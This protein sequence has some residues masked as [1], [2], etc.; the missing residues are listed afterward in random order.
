MKEKQS[1]QGQLLKIALPVTL[2]SLLQSS[3]SIV[4]Q[5]M[6]GQLGSVSIAGIGM[7]SKFLSLYTVVISAVA[8][9][10]GIMIAQYIGNRNGKEVGRS[11]YTN[12][13]FAVCI[14]L[15]FTGICLI[16]PGHI[17]SLYS[18]DAETIAMAS[19]Y[20]RIFSLSCI[21]AALAALFSTCLRCMGYASVPL[22]TTI[23]AAVL[24]TAL[25]YVMIFGRFGCPAMGANGAACAS[26]ISQLCGCILLVLI[27]FRLHQKHRW[28]LPPGLLCTKKS[29]LQYA[30][31]ILPVFICEFFWSLGENV[32]AMIYGHLGTSD[33]AA[34]TL[35]N[36]I[37]GLMIGALSGMSQ[38]A[39][40]MTGKLLGAKRFEEAYKTSK[41]LMR[42]G[43]AGSLL[44]SF[45]LA[46]T[47]RYYVM[48]FQV[49]TE[50][51]LTAANILLVFALISPVKVQNMILG[52]GI[53]RSGGKT[54]YVMAVD[55]IGTWLFGVPLGLLSAFLW[56]QS[57]PAVYFFLSLEECVRFG[58][59]LLIFKHKRWMQSLAH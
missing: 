39:A 40:I 21:P 43:F 28:Q 11:F 51:R 49:E 23:L 48:I 1:F 10:A 54:K 30:G 33:F 9:A 34:M 29:W 25:N 41:K 38:A 31:I 4:D 42:Y 22:Y 44:L 12:L 5:I 3:F 6:T 52:G 8:A 37:Q 57:I 13:L 15:L 27:F 45:L 20:L 36:P 7:G 14:A 56:K 59:T 16:L 24:N 18:R 2:Q 55:L 47:C 19:G 58:I 32:Y 26:V 50:V 17:M 53:I 46:L 35:T